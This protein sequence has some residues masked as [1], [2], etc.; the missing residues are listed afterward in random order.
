MFG[1]PEYGKR[2]RKSTHGGNTGELPVVSQGD[3]ERQANPFFET[4]RLQEIFLKVMNLDVMARFYSEVIGLREIGRGA[5]IV[6]LSATGREPALVVLRQDPAFIPRSPAS[7]GL[8]HIALLYPDRRELARAVR[9][10]GQHNWRFQGFADHGV[11][12]AAYL[13]DPEGNGLELYRDKPVEEWPRKENGVAMVTEPLNVQE[14]I[15]EIDGEELSSGAHPETMV[16]HVHLQVSNLGRAEDFYRGVLGL[17]VTQKDYPGALFLSNNGYHHHFGL[18]IWNSRGVEP[19]P[20]DA[21]GLE[22]LTL[23]VDRG[24]F[25]EITER[26]ASQIPQSFRLEGEEAVLAD[27]DGILTKIVSIR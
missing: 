13:A 27:S 10:A 15:A 21:T 11:S 23:C 5:G 24:R 18:N 26:A 4:T 7:P 14:L 8:F 1:I 17:E 3:M 19:G 6:R 25:E 20:P 2:H 12:E 16:G 22:I 9:N